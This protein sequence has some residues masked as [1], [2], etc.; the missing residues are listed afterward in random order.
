MSVAILLACCACALA[1]DPSLDVSQYAHTSWK[2][3]DGFP[4]GIVYAIAQTPD[5]YLWL[6]TEV[7]LFRFDGV[8]SVL[9]QATTDHLP[10]NS[11]GSLLAAKDGSL[12]IGTNNGV[13][14][15]KD[16]KLTQ[17][18]ELT[19][20]HFVSLVQDREGTV[21]AGG[22]ADSSGRLC[23]IQSSKV[24]C[25]GQDG[26][27]GRGVVSLV[28]D[29]RGGLW[30]GTNAGVW[31]WKPGS[32]RYYRLLNEV[33]APGGVIEGDKGDLLIALRREIRQLVDGKIEAYDLPIH[34][35][36]FKPLSLLRDRNG[37]LW[38]GTL[39][40]GLL[41]V[42]EGRTDVFAQSD[43]LS[44]DFI[45]S[46][47]EDREG[48]IWV[49]TLNGLDRFRDFAVATVSLGQGLSNSVVWSV[50]A[51][52]DGS[53]WTGTPD[54]LNRWKDGQV[55]IYRKRGEFREGEREKWRSFGRVRQITGSGLPDN[56]IES[57]FEDDR[58]RVWVSTRRGVAYLENGRFV[59]LAA[60]PG[61]VH[62]ISGDA[63]GNLWISQDQ[64]LFHLFRGSL[65][66]QIPWATIGGKTGAVPMLLSD[67]LRGGL[68][69]GFWGEGGVAYFKDGKV[70]ARYAIADGLGK[71]QVSD[72][73][74]DQ[75]GT[76]W[77][78]TE[79]GLSR[80]KNEHVATLTSKNGLPCDT[81]HWSMEDDDRSFWLYTACGLLRIARAELDAWIADPQRTIQ[82]TVFD[83]SD[84]VRSHPTTSGYSPRVTKAPDGEFWFLPFDGVSVIDPHHIP[85][86]KLPPPVHIEQIVADR[87]TYDT[88]S[89]RSGN[90]GLPPLIRDLE[91]DYTALSLVAPEKNRFRYKL[92]GLDKDWHDVGNRR[93]AFYTNLPPRHYRFRVAAA[94]NSGVWNEEGAFLDFNIAPAYYQTNWFRSLCGLTFLA[95]LWT[96][97]RLRVNTLKR[98]Q[99][100][101][102]QHQ[103]LL[104]RHQ[105]EI[106]ALNEQMIKAQEAERMRIS[107]DLHDGVLQQI[108]SLTLRL[109]KVKR[110]VPP[111]S[112][113]TAT[114][115]SLQQQ[116]IQIGTDIRHISHELHPALLQESGLPAA[117]SSYC[118][119]FSNVRGLP[120]SCE[121]DE[122]VQELSPGAALCLYRIAQEA[123]GNAAKYSQARKV[124]VRLTRSNGLV[125]LTVSDDGVGCD[126]ERIGK[127][128]G[129]GVI[130]MRERVLQLRGTFEFKSETGR[131]TTVK[132]EVPFRPAS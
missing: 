126:P 114:V 5:G 65:I 83:S 106:R 70:Q 36:E 16:G 54:G 46:L 116:L 101:L 108:T 92:E 103:I 77:A 118:E 128:G 15:L 23:A 56:V 4:K 105:V 78:A 80:I 45:K 57:L 49:A 87:K 53:V 91:I 74:L 14:S 117:L 63:E 61:G 17:Y 35:A 38:I 58:G 22:N 33:I 7:G 124:E 127:S 42:H 37:G 12:W 115:N 39:D 25:Y 88:A 27:L 13:A 104:E 109:G 123:L 112:E 62:S 18:P 1:L 93:Q 32:P 55:T 47:F 29:R 97:Y 113:A 121:T 60:V 90:L 125:C 85:F 41:H 110:Q 75:D 40:R 3:R 28:E 76:L 20:H 86:N 107:G 52:T 30:A 130:N 59:S 10:G 19:G 31:K 68:W 102:E 11:V 98:K 122:S 100:A 99:A 2:V 82:A 132:A 9:W 131:G 26:S 21:W 119:E 81:V 6:G 43:G 66:D 67:P 111:D 24:Q 44:G 48:N 79:G 72:L 34:G 96:V 50:L 71:G 8:R 95:M 64:S 69:L 51:A 129:L 94:N 89:D 120:V 84:G 73:Q